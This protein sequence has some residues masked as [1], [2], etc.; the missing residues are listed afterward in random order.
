VRYQI[1]SYAAANERTRLIGCAR[2]YMHERIRIVKG[3]DVHSMSELDIPIDLEA[4]SSSQCRGKFPGFRKTD[5]G[6]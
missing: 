1:I 2:L 3:N 4:E 5:D 6:D